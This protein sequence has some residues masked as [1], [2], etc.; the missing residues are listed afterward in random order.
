MHA[1]DKE[2]LM[3]EQL[4]GLKPGMIAEMEAWLRRAGQ[5]NGHINAWVEDVLGRIADFSVR[6]KMVR[7]GLVQLG[8]RSLMGDG[9]CLAES[10]A[11]AATQTGVVMELL[12]SLLLI[13]DDIMDQDDRRRGHPSMHAQYVQAAAKAGIAQAVRTGES[14]AICAGDACAFL[15]MELLAEIEA[16]PAALAKLM[17]LVSHEL[18]VVVFAQMGDVWNGAAAGDPGFDEILKLYR[19]KTGRYT[20]SLPLMAGARLAG[21]G[22]AA[23]DGLSG[24]GE[25]M[26]I[27]FQIRD[28]DIG[29]FADAA[30]TGKPRGTDI[31]ENKKTLHR[32]FLLERCDVAERKAMAAIFGNPQAGPAEIDRLLAAMVANGVRDSIAAELDF[33]AGQARELVNRL[34]G[35][36]P[37]GRG[38]LLSL[39]DWNLS[40]GS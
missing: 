4:G 12:Q 6:G 19:Y 18:T 33:Y 22:E 17:S 37:W 9:T 8:C 39:V 11:R 36:N 25:L 34:P 20:F 24:L 30:Q 7:G 1:G 2:T 27:L 26:G 38:F 40:R 16:P 10:L 32:H 29:L 3:L 35:L 31:R 28:D 5:R 13:H 23:V 15:A 14:M 21:A